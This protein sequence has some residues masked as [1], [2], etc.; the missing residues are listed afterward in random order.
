MSGC[1]DFDINIHFCRDF[2]WGLWTRIVGHL[3]R[4][5]PKWGPFC[6]SVH[7]AKGCWD[8][9]RFLPT[10]ETVFR[11]KPPEVI[12]S[13]QG[14][15]C[16]NRGLQQVDQCVA[17]R[18]ALEKGLRSA[19]EPHLAPN[20]AGRHR[21]QRFSESNW[22]LDSNT[23]LPEHGLVHRHL[24][25]PKGKVVCQQG[26]VQQCLAGPISKEQWRLTFV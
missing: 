23:D 11:M 18:S 16:R 13:Y 15:R 8:F 19:D 14:S 2:G 1:Q 24:P 5:P 4:G 7:F 10:N 20:S 6:T 21:L 9:D 25:F 12:H 26:S 22:V 3:L 17:K